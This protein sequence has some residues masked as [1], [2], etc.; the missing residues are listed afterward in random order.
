MSEADSAR[1][2]PL[3]GRNGP[4]EGSSRGAIALRAGAVDAR[5]ASCPADSPSRVGQ[6]RL[7]ERRGLEDLALQRRRGGEQARVDVRKRL[8]HVLPGRALE[9]GGE[10]QQLQIAHHPVGDVQVGVQPQLAEAP[11]DPRDAREHLLAHQ[12]KRR[13]EL[14]SIRR[15]R[16]RVLGGSAV[17]RPPARRPRLRS[18]RSASGRQRHRARWRASSRGV[19]RGLLRTK[20]TASS[21]SCSRLARCSAASSGASSGRP[22]TPRRSIRRPMNTSGA[23][24]SSSAAALGAARRT[25][26]CARAPRAGPAAT[27]WRL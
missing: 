6:Q 20:S 18:P 4:S 27:R 8:R 19:E 2:I 21:R 1:P 9:Q 13:L 25:A 12:L 5:P 24:L 15:L 11:A 16:R 7:V 17:A 22:R 3:R 26:G 14:G 10:L 23:T